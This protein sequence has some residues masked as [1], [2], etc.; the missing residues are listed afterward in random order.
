MST[1]FYDRRFYAG[2]G[3]SKQGVAIV[4]RGGVGGSSFARGDRYG[5]D[6]L[7]ASAV[8]SATGVKAPADGPPNRSPNAGNP[9]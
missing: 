1:R 7:N 3:V 4:G 9:L 8:H 6:L 5:L 2:D